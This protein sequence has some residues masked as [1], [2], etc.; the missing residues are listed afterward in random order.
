[1]SA[2]FGRWDFAGQPPDLDH[3]DKADRMLARYA[4]DSSSAYRLNG[5]SILFRAF[6]TTNES[7]GETQPS[8]MESGSVITWDGRL[9]N[10]EE[11]Q[12]Q[13][14]R[15]SSNV[16]DAAVVAATYRRWDVN[17]LQR[18][19][20]D[21]AVSIW[22][23][24]E[25]CLLLA[26]DQ[27]GTRHLYYLLERDRFTWSTVLDPIVLLAGR[28]FELE[29]DYIA[30]WLSSLPPADLTPYK[31]IHS[32]PPACYVLVR[33]GDLRVAPYWS[34]DPNK[35]IEYP[36][37]GDYEEH[38]RSAFREAVRR[39]LRSDSPVLAELSGGMDSSSIVCV[40]DGVVRH[41]GGIAS[42]VDTVSYYDDSEP[43][44]NERPYFTRIEE[45]RGRRGLHIDVGS[46]KALAFET[47]PHHFAATPQ[48]VGPRST[49]L[50]QLTAGM[51]RQGNRVILSGVGGDEVTGGVPDP[52][53]EL[54]DLLAE[55]RLLLLARQLS[56]WALNR[57]TPWY[58]LLAEALRVL[59]APVI[60]SPSPD[61]SA[62]P[63]LTLNVINR[64]GASRT[65][66]R[67]KG[68]GRPSFRSNLHALEMLK[69][70][71]SCTALASVSLAE[72]RYPYLDRELLEFL[73]AIPREQLVRPGQRRSLLRRAMSG[74]VPP[75]ILNRSRKA[76]VVRAPTKAITS[77]LPA[78]LNLAEHMQC[79]WFEMVDAKVF[80]ERLRGAQRG[81]EVAITSMLR[82]LATEVWLRNLSTS[83]LQRPCR[84]TASPAS[85]AGD[86][87]QTAALL[88]PRPWFQLK[89]NPP[90]RR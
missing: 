7:R 4:P 46:L 71:L 83:I 80:A 58:Q 34:F 32:V 53:P 84:P 86:P 60:G 61:V 38:F 28:P 56:A 48:T 90:E 77:N 8:I 45:K 42:R 27:V 65:A 29:R 62:T 89:P 16:T 33:P 13:L 68:S 44:W 40:A 75:E 88:H 36:T 25:C 59:V 69:R 35:R 26:K 52:V 1:M 85:G 87:D 14:G 37:D 3:F 66:D 10:I 43:N 31:G 72:Y 19:V 12:H 22:N 23:P 55:G 50:D 82:T 18:F 9:D 30:G 73:Y 24:K 6:H 67:G 63:W 79:E 15:P 49:A 41:C 39:R 2:Q 20:G 64:P 51:M 54:A 5:M 78:L 70:Q 57:R 21:W 11:L 47:D 74:I 17:C 76:F 81:E